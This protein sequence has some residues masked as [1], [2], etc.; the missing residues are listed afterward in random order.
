DET[1]Y[2][3]LTTGNT[4]GVFQLESSGMKALVKELKPNQFED[5]NALVA[6][7]RPG[8]LNSGMVEE[9]VKRKHGKAKIEYDH[10]DLEPIL[11]ATY[12]A[13]VYQEQIMQVAQTLAGYSLG[14][15]DI[16]RR[17]MGK[18]KKEEMDKQRETFL[19]GTAK[20]NLDEKIATKLFDAMTA[21]A[22]Y[23]F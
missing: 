8:P 23:C 2:K 21:F 22:E 20:R 15:A 11:H 16:L 13:V 9:F 5:I 6:L 7:F 14:Q 10:P 1:V 19:E 3:M 18:K 4:D 17:A 12:G